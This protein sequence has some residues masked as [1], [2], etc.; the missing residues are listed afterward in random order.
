MQAPSLESRKADVLRAVVVDYIRTGEPVGSGVLARRY[1]LRVSSATIRND[2]SLLE[3]MGYLSQ[4]HTSAGRIPTDLGYRFYVDT[5]P[6]SPVPAEAHRRAI[7]AFFGHPV[8]DVEEVLRRT[9][10]LLS[11]LTHYGAVTQPPGA[12]HVFIGG[13]ANI[14]SE[15]LFQRRDTA[16][17]LFEA[18]EEHEDD[19]LGLLR[20]LWSERPVAIRIGG[21]NPLPAMREASLVVGAYRVHGRPAGTVAVIGPTRMQYRTAISAVHTVATRLSHLVESLAG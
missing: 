14:A 16:Q 6:A 18:L 8:D 9:A 7:A 11:R 15:E 21:E 12:H 10:L 13:A 17:R 1:R 20:S 19:V 3:E 2:M 5:L 4:P